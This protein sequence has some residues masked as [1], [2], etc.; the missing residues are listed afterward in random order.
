MQYKLLMHLSSLYIV[1]LFSQC[2]AQ[3]QEFT[4]PGSFKTV[5]YNYTVITNN[6]T[7][8]SRLTRE[9]RILAA[10]LL[11]Q[12]SIQQAPDFRLRVEALLGDYKAALESLAEIRSTAD[13]RDTPPLVHM[14]Y[15]LFLRS[16]LMSTSNS[17]EFETALT[18][19]F[20]HIFD[21]LSNKDAHTAGYYF[22]YSLEQGIQ[23]L[24]SAIQRI[25]DSETFDLTTAAQLI[26]TYQDLLVYSAVLPPSKALLA[27]DNLQRYI[28]E[29]DVLI[30]GPDGIVLSAAIV[31]DR[32]IEEPMPS[33][34]LYTI[35][36]YE[37][38]N[39]RE[40]LHAA[41]HG[42]VGVVADARGKRLSTGEITPYE[43]E[44][45]DVNA[46][47]D[48][49]SQQKWSDG[50]VAMYGGSYNGFVQWAALKNPHPALKTIVPYVAAI[51]GL[52]LPMENNIF[53]NANYG[54]AFYV[55]NNRTLDFE[56]Y[57]DQDRWNRLNTD[58]YQSGRSYREIDTID[59]TPNPWLQ[60]WLSHPSYDEFW[61][62]MVP[63]K[64]EYANIDIPILSITGYY[65]D[66]QVSAL[67]YLNEHVRYHTEPNHYLLIGPYDHRTAQGRPFP[68]LRGIG[69][70]QSALIDVPE[71]TFEWL[72]HIL[73]NAPRPSLI[74]GRVNYQVM[75]TN[76]WR[77]ESSMDA[78]HAQSKRYYLIN[79]KEGKAHNLDPTPA[80]IADGVLQKIDFK[81]RSDTHNNNYPWP[82]IKDQLDTSN[83][84]VYFSAP[85]DED[86]EISGQFSGVLSIKINKHDADIGVTLYEILP[87]GHAFHLS[88]YIGRASYALDMSKRKV[89][90]PGKVELVPIKRSRMIS[91]R[92]QAGSRIAVVLN[93]NVNENAQINYGTGGDVSDETIANAE[94]PLIVTW[95]SDS[96]ID[97]PIRKPN[98][99]D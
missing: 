62:S 47:I 91:K 37:A 8:D 21:K 99:S 54:W 29:R 19:V 78:L 42:Y 72:D 39:F 84:V 57:F 24:R 18:T 5:N 66:G 74:K 75:G 64:T 11:K 83:G 96:Y 36:N 61:Q 40:A 14:E 10:D 12:P 65:D 44:A 92:L 82:I 58:W 9:L 52:G 13:A 32:S 27:K 59:G 86:V 31:R 85:L 41:A 16:H 6:L 87:D 95:R 98:L 97:L 71:L 49:I 4:A 88:Y 23:Y 77:H 15:E 25:T 80:S 30:P 51:P 3:A 89:L 81:D 56:T 68:T 20:Q 73:K 55:A 7:D 2:Q 35:Y 43:T 50:Q 48:W 76:Q 67:Q 79:S 46:V 22:G 33:A 34:L 93:V 17:T 26:R 90:T 45:R 38:S 28:V 53:L 63:Y 69:L 70:D 94:T 1:V 60:K